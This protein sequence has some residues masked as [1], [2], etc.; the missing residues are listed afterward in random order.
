[1][2]ELFKR[3]GENYSPQKGEGDWESIAKRIADKASSPTVTRPTSNSR[4]KKIIA[5]FLSLFMLT[6]GSFIIE[7]TTTTS[8]TLT[9]QNEARKR[10]NYSSGKLE[11]R[12][13]NVGIQKE[14]AAVAFSSVEKSKDKDRMKTIGYSRHTVSEETT[15]GNAFK[16]Y[17]K[18][19]DQHLN[20]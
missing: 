19:K 13:N 5:L 11:I 3:A 14:D 6:V 17:F 9:K 20:K 1:M 16:T 18:N 4:N 2:E 12:N 7:S 10:A 8:S 15:V